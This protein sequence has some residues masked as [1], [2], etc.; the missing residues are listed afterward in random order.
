MAL[1]IPEADSDM[2]RRA[3]NVPI[4]WNIS[5]MPDRAFER[6]GDDVRRLERRHHAELVALDEFDGERA[7]PRRQDAIVGGRR[8]AALQ[9]PEHDVPGFFFRQR[10]QFARHLLANAAEPLDAIR[11]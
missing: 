6:H 8:T 2:S 5:D 10:F 3:N 1:G 9:M 7:E 4:D 11:G